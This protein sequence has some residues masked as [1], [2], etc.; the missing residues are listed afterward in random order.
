MSQANGDGGAGS[1]GAA[2]AVVLAA[3]LGPPVAAAK[4]ATSISGSV[5]RMAAG[6]LSA[7]PDANFR[8]QEVQVLPQRRRRREIDA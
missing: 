6:Y 5:A 1:A 4:A 3:V 7:A 8:E 2:T